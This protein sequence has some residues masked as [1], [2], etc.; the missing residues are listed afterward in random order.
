MKE[1]KAGVFKEK[2]EIFIY[3]QSLLTLNLVSSNVRTSEFNGT[4]M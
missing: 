3:Q 1:H 2:Y 4:S